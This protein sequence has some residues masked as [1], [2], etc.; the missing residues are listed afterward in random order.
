LSYTAEGKAK[1]LDTYAAVKANI[2]TILARIQKKPNEKGFM[3]VR[4]PKLSD[5]LLM[6]L[7]GGRTMALHNVEFSPEMIPIKL[8]FLYY[9]KLISL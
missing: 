3:P 9:P 6:F 2:D 8:L 7:P 1:P 5:L 4:R